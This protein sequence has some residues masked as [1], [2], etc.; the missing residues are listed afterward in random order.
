MGRKACRNEI[1]E[2]FC[3]SIPCAPLSLTDKMSALH[4][5]ISLARSVLVLQWC[6]AL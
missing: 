3:Q 5:V 2:M 1:L 4:L 6:I